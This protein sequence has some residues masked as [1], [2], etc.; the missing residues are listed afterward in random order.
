MTVIVLAALLICSTSTVTAVFLF[1]RLQART[2]P[3]LSAATADL[4]L[5]EQGLLITAVL[6][7][8]AAA[9]A[10]L[11]RGDILLR[12]NEAM[13][14][15]PE[16]L[17]QVIREHEA[18]DEIELLVLRGDETA[19]YPIT[20]AANSPRL[21]LEVLAARG[22]S[23]PVPASSPTPV[24]FPVIG[25]VL[26]DSPA[27]AAGLAAGDE[28]TAVDGGT[29][30]GRDELITLVQAKEPDDTMTLTVRR[31][32]ETLILSVTLADHPDTTIGHGFLGIELA[33]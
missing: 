26:A 21:G 30:A 11:R 1:N 2:N 3:P 14:D 22:V 23:S 9:Q 5:S 12:A 20:I 16:D 7:E 15:T 31:S 17:Q 29:L 18:G 8:A 4:P 32:G 10:G 27:A 33:P 6:P 19:V 13:L 28:I 24:A 25:R